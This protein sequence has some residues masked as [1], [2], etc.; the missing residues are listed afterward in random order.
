MN[1]YID[2]LKSSI[3]AKIT[4]ALLGIIVILGIYCF[5]QL[6]IYIPTNIMI[7]AIVVFLILMGLLWL[8]HFKVP[9]VS[10]VLEVIVCACLIVG[11]FAVN[12][13]TT[14]TGKVTET[15]EVETVQIVAL[16]DS[17]ITR[18]DAFNKLT[19]AYLQ[20]DDTAYTR[21][22]EILKENNKTVQKEIPYKSMETAYNDLKNQKVDLLV[23]T[24]LSKSDLSSV[25]ENY[26][27]Q[28]KVILSKDYPFDSVK[29]KSVN[30]AKEPFTIYFQ[31]ADLSSGDNINSVGRGDVNI[32]LT[33]NPNTKQ[34]NM[35]VIPRDLFVYIPCKDASS[36][37][38]YSG[39]WGGIQ[40][41][42]ASIEKALDVEINYYAKINFTGLTDLVDALGGV[43]VYSHYTYNAGGYNFV[44]GYND[45]D[46]PKALMFARARK[47]LPLN[48]R[49]RGYQ[50]MEL[51]KGIFTKFAQEP[52][53]NH[54]MSVIDSLENNFTTNLPK[55]DFVKA[56]QIV[57]DLLPKLQ[58][59]ENH[60]IE[61][62]YKW[63]NDEVNSNYLY[64]FY[65][66]DG[67]IKAVKE[68]IDNVLNGK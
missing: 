24:N 41:S 12:K 68:R 58:T 64:Y 27:D 4:L 61:G 1:K 59:M 54:A 32:L 52:T 46:G 36:K 7:I 44:K 23:L 56:Y 5:V 40:S 18:D 60:S 65:P 21:S 29:A 49:S 33:V 11:V 67:E 28:I 20:E 22:S 42:I 6:F 50:Q 62:E 37:L 43:K 39:W 26:S 13:V 15:N 45:V 10:L 8:S 48:E 34:V 55:E 31:G 17:K 3:W 25:D 63:H 35:Q 57:L 47:M 9:K 66:N 16:K 2:Y 51:I 38:S 19:M 14:F 53:Y 30:I